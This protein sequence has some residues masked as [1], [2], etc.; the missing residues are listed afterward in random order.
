[1]QIN[2]GGARTPKG[3]D[4][5]ENVYSDAWEMTDA[6]RDE[7]EKSRPKPKRRSAPT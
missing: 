1:M 6:Y 3:F 5:P 2:D 4:I 7:W